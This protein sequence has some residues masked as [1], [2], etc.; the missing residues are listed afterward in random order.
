MTPTP[1]GC[2]EWNGSRNKQ[3]YGQIT[4]HALMK[5]PIATHRLAFY[6]THGFWPPVV[7]HKCDNPPCCNPA[8]LLEGTIQKNNA[9]MANKM[10]A[11]KPPTKKWCEKHPK[12]PENMK[13]NGP[14]KWTCRACA[15]ERQR[16]AYHQS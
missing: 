16:R 3:G 12:T 15:K 2:W 4:R 10:R 7:M 6:L 11:V 1:D 13:P 5:R 8:H 9:D 14:G